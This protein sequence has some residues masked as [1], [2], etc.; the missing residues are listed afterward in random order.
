[1]EELG[2]LQTVR[3]WRENA[4][5]NAERLIAARDDPAEL[6]SVR[7]SIEE[8]ARTIALSIVAGN[9]LPGYGATRDAHCRSAQQGSE[10]RRGKRKRRG[11]EPAATPGP[12]LPDL[13][14]LPGGIAGTVGGLAD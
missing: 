7:A 5:R 12:D 1:V 6:S 4:W 10:R 9:T 11:D 3:G 8:E 13:P 14:D 2:V